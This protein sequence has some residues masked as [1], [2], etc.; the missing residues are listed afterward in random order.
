MSTHVQGSWCWLYVYGLIHGECRVLGS[1]RLTVSALVGHVVHLRRSRRLRIR[2]LDWISQTFI[3]DSE[4]LVRLILFYWL[5]DAIRLWLVPPWI[6]LLK[7]W[8]LR[9]HYLRREGTN[10]AWRK[11]HFTYH[12]L[13]AV[14]G[15]CYLIKVTARFQCAACEAVG[16]WVTLGM[17]GLR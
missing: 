12:K 3:G 1:N 2:L 17:L 9:R 11:I 6:H 4:T 8:S 13:F 15:K 16:W 14:L 5:V 10:I 7:I